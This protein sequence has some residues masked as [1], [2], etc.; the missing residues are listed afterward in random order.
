MMRPFPLYSRTRPGA[1]E[2][3][4]RCTVP[5][6]TRLAGS[7]AAIRP[8]G[9]TLSRWRPAT[10]PPN[11]SKNHHGTPLSVDSTAVSGP[12]SGPMP[13]TAA[14]SDWALTASTTKS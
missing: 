10:G 2:L 3:A 12:S 8:P 5:P 1:G 9:S 13:V 7:T 11:P 14:G 6:I 4:D